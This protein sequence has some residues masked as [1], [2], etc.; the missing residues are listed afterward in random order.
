MRGRRKPGL[1]TRLYAIPASHSVA[2]ATHML[3]L[4]G[5]EY[6]RV[7]LPHAIHRWLIPRLGFRDRT[8][9]A[10]RIAGTHVQGTRAIA[11]VLDELVSEP[12]LLPA[13]PG[14]RR[15][16]E[17]AERWGDE[18]LQ[19]LPRRLVYWALSRD[20]TPVASF[21]VGARFPVPLPARLAAPLVIRLAARN[22]GSSDEAVRAD[23]AALPGL[24]DRID[25]WIGDGRL[26]GDPPNAA[27]FQIA[28]SVRLLLT[29]DDLCPAIEP[30][31]AGRHAAQV[32]PHSP[33]RVG[34]VF[35][36]AWLEPLGLQ[37]LP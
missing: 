22:V 31:P 7:D 16:V 10:L 25:A 18:V 4:K 6:E 9:P 37:S 14:R 12:P 29:F 26:G 28:A 36:G 23:L 20:R 24:L 3:D 21:L 17:E 33:G 27:D 1:G 32:V 30:R 8:V 5:V 2:A 34:P 11:R 19:P 13:D 35:P 15:A